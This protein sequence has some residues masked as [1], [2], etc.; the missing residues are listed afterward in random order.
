MGASI[1]AIFV[2]PIC[3]HSKLVAI[4]DLYVFRPFLG[5]NEAHA[6]LI[7]DPDRMLSITIPAQS[8][9]P[10]SRRRAQII[11]VNRSVKIAE[12]PADDFHKVSRKA[13]RALALIDRFGH[14][15]DRPVT[16]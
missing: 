7:V 6:E 11:Q 8:L 1:L 4:G 5:P 16:T 3:D 2:I 15:L 10:I 9:K 13:F 12:F 14:T